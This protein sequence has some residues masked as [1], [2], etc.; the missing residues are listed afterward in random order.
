MRG[1]TMLGVPGT[2]KSA[3]AKAL[4]NESGRPT[5]TLDVGALMGSLVGETEGRTRQALGLID[6]MSPCITFIDEVDKALA[7]VQQP[8][9]S[10]DSGVSARLF[11][12]F[13]SWLS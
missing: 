2:G 3:V 13:L 11:G 4:G 8:G 6:A 5:L 1:L 10:G 7:G 9:A 12:S